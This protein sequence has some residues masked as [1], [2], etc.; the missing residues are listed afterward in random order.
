MAEAVAERVDPEQVG[1]LGVTHRDVTGHALAETE[2]AEDAQGAGELGLAVGT[3][4]LDGGERSAGNGIVRSV[5]GVN[6]MPS[7]V[8]TSSSVMAMPQ[9]Y[10]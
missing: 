7:I 10:R 3:L 6:G 5:L 8:R 1:E 9:A 4:L 2:P